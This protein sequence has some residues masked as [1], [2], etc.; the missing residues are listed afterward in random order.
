MYPG[1]WKTLRPATP[2]EIK[3]T[4]VL[5]MKIDEGAAKIRSGPPIDD[6]EDYGWPAWAGVVPVRG[7]IGP[8]QDDG[9]LASG[10]DSPGRRPSR[11]CSAHSYSDGPGTIGP[12]QRTLSSVNIVTSAAM[13]FIHS[14]DDCSWRQMRP[15]PGG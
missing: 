13:E 5:H 12:S 1:R 14:S 6:D 2:Q 9:R 4:T 7:V 15:A 8:A 10:T 11:T 3:A